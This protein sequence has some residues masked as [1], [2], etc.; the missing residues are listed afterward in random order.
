MAAAP[1]RYAGMGLKDLG[2]EMWAHMKKSRQGHWQA[3]AYATLPTPEMTPRR[4][5]QRLM[6]GDVEKVPLGQDGEP[7]R[8]ASA[9]FP[10]RPAF[11]S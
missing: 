3:Q 8:R 5:F 7:R 4:A 10:T 1:E 6:A 11:R 9:S 2:D